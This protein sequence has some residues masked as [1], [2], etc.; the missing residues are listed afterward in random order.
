MDKYLQIQFARFIASEEKIEMASGFWV[1]SHWAWIL[2]IYV[3]QP[4]ILPIE[5]RSFFM[6]AICSIEQLL[7]DIRILRKQ[8]A[9][10]RNGAVSFFWKH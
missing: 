8:Q 5:I 9:D 10:I 4:Y 2:R 3:A 7:L 1:Y 6:R